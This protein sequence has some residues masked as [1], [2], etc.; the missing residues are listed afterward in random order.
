MNTREKI[1]QYTIVAI[2]VLAAV[3]S[4]LDTFGILEKVSFLSGL[5]GLTPSLIVILLSLVAVYL[6]FERRSKLDRIDRIT[7]EATQ[8]LIGIEEQTRRLNELSNIELLRSARE[9]GVE[10]LYSRANSERLHGIVDGIRNAKGPIDICGVA[11]PSMVEN[12]EFREA[13]LDHGRKYDVRIMLLNPDSYEAIRRKNIEEPLGR[14]TVADIIATCSWIE[15]Q[16]IKNGRFRLHFYDIPPMLSLIITD[17]FIFEEPYHFG[18][19]EGLEGCIGGHVPMLKIR[20]QPEK[21]TKNPYSFFKAHFEY[22]WNFTRGTRANLPIQFLEAKPSTYI[23]LENQTGKDI[24]MRGWE[25][26]GQESLRPFQF[27]SDYI[28][29]NSDRIIIARQA[30]DLPKGNRIFM[31]ETDFMGNNTIL[32]LTNGPGTLTNEWSIPLSVDESETQD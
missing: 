5:S 4:V 16:V 12:D 30:E 6:I 1:E 2:A 31:T 23:V 32:R 26:T 24:A 11:L 7:A 28:W 29:N 9:S 25:I 13:V 20:N 17:Q 21:G 14:K 19:P 18:R 22:L 27:E 3:F 8:R 15:E 10:D